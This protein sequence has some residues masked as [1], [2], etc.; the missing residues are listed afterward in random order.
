[1]ALTQISTGGVKDDAVTAGKIPANAI[2]SSE[3]ADDAVDQGAIADEAVDEARL[4]ISNAGS[5]GQFLQKQSGNTGGLTWAAANEYT[6]PNHSGEVTSTADGAQVIASN[7]VDE[8][9][10]KI[11]NAGSNGQFLSKQSGNTGGLTWATVESAPTITATASGAIAANKSVYVKNDG[12]VSQVTQLGAA[13]AANE[14]EFEAGDFGTTVKTNNKATAYDVT[15]KVVLCVYSDTGNNNKHTAVAGTVTSAGV[16]TWGTPVVNPNDND[17][18]TEV[19]VCW[20]SWSGK[21]VAAFRDNGSARGRLCVITVSGTTVS[22]PGN[23]NNIAGNNDMSWISIAA[24]PQGNRCAVVYRDHDNSYKLMSRVI[25]GFN[26][27]TPNPETFGATE[28]HNDNHVGMRLIHD[29]DANRAILV[30][31]DTSNSYQGRVWVG[32]C[33]S[34]AVSWNSPQTFT[35]N[36]V[37][38]GDGGGAQG[39]IDLVYS[40][41]LDRC[42]VAWTSA[43]GSDDRIIIGRV[44]SV[45]STSV[46]FSASQATLLDASDYDGIQL[47]AN[48]VSGHNS[49]ILLTYSDWEDDR[50]GKANILTLSNSGATI[51]VGS[52]ET[53]NSDVTSSKSTQNISTVFN[54]DANAHVVVY[55]DNGDSN[56]G[57]SIARIQDSTDMT[58]ENFVG[59]SSAGYSNGDTAKINVVGN[60]TTQSSL[61]PG[62]KYY[63]QQDGTLGLTASNP[64]VEAGIALSST[65]LLIR[66]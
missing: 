42:L 59:F 57:N 43:D 21:F 23:V 66:Q 19:A 27:S 7:I 58:T 40:E 1:M 30:A 36:Y 41:G 46:T 35:T 11:S 3:I 16:I 51:T 26:D 53:F 65:K 5:N 4:Q 20:D 44:F 62:R 15:N 33:G 38:T 29:P 10:L 47:S 14:Y 49:K 2:G 64:N 24:F 8:D 13:F 32:T 6:H 37:L 63:V 28:I 39:G 9:N 17:G 18:V 25:Y 22:F 48:S 55:T 54:K 34:S 52:Q 31:A 45:G 61:T 60:T 12:T 56:K 50:K